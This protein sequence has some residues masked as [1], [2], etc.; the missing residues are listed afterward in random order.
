MEYYKYYPER[1][2]P[3]NF[4]EAML[5]LIKANDCFFIPPISQ[6]VSVQGYL[7][8]LLGRNEEYIKKK[9]GDVPLPENP[10]TIYIPRD[11]NSLAGF[12]SCFGY[13]GPFN[14]GYIVAIMTDPQLRNNGIGTILFNS[15]LEEFYRIGT[16]KI[17]VT[18]WSTNMASQRLFF[19][20]GFKLIKVNP[21]E[22]APGVD[23]LYFEKEISSEVATFH[24]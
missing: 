11:E 12:V 19:K 21:N 20:F 16:K 24:L 10:F 8:Y 4:L 6:R 9:Y 23:G 22:R 5:S 3:Q 7:E 1:V 14:G 15:A 2:P 13:F 17:S 18:T